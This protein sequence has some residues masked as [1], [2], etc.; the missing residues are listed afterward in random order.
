MHTEDVDY[1]RS[2][3]VFINFF[4]TF[5]HSSLYDEGY[6]NIN[7]NKTPNVLGHIEVLTINSRRYIP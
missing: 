4:N 3:K 1:I 5:F 7:N 2:G 6:F